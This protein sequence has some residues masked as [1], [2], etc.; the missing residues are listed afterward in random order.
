MLPVNYFSG[1]LTNHFNAHATLTFSEEE[2]DTIFANASL[3]YLA[4][5]SQLSIPL[6]VCINSYY[7]CTH[8]PCNVKGECHTMYENAVG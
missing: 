2:P 6:N 7:V 8:A 1:T 3:S 5:L 4:V